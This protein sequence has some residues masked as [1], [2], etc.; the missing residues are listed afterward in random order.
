MLV[1]EKTTDSPVITVGTCAISS[2]PINIAEAFG[3]RG[4]NVIIAWGIRDDSQACLHNFGQMTVTVKPVI[5]AP[6]KSVPWLVTK[7]NGSHASALMPVQDSAS[8][9]CCGKLTYAISLIA[10]AVAPSTAKSF[11]P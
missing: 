1:I 3:T 10:M 4:A 11:R 6:F 7:S 5:T 2:A 9:H 8:S